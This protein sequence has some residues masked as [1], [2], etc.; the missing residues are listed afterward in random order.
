[1]LNVVSDVNT[2]ALSLTSITLTVISWEPE[3]T[4]SDAVTV[5]EYEVLV[6]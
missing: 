2:G 3:F 5:A 6:S 4:P 1:M